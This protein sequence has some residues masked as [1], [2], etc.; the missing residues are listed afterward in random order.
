[1]L[2]IMLWSHVPASAKLNPISSQGLQ[3]TAKHVEHSRKLT[4]KSSL[5]VS[6]SVDA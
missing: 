5:A 6:D 4:N 1:M 2:G 3:V